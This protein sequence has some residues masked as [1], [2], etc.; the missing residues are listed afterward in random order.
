MMTGLPPL[1]PGLP[2]RET[3]FELDERT[4][5]VTAAADLEALLL[6]DREIEKPPYWA[7]LWPAGA[8][9]AAHLET[10]RNLVR[11]VTLELGCG[12]GLAGIVARCHGARVLQ[13]DLFPEA[14]ALARWNA[15]RNSVSGIRYLAMD[16]TRWSVR[17]AFDRIL[18]ADILYER[19][20]HAPL[21]AIFETNLA[22][23]GEVLIADPDRPLAMVFAAAMERAGWRVSVEA[24]PGE[25]AVFL[26]RFRRG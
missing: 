4:L 18:G 13:T 14:V 25:P 19:G 15:R 23:G 12:A 10:Q 5:V 6:T 2:R 1:P 11:K 24:L 26:Y 8:A 22:V 3:R 17:G 20:L 21:Q 7:V 16:W 9:L